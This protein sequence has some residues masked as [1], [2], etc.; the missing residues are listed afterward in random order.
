VP[1][2]DYDAKMQAVAWKDALEKR[3]RALLRLEHEASRIHGQE[4][5]VQD[6]YHE[7]MKPYTD[8]ERRLHQCDD[9]EED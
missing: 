9:D 3:E 2:S 1:A 5:L 8:T 7:R 4:Q 6:L